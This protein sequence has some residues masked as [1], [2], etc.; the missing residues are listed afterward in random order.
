MRNACNTVAGSEVLITGGLGFIGSNLAQQLVKAEAKVTILDAMLESYGGN[1]TNVKGIEDKIKIVIGDIRD[2]ET[3][4]RLVDGKDYI[5]HLAAQ[6]AHV[7]SMQHPYLDVDINCN[8]TLNLLEACRKMG[9]RVKVVYSGTR[10]QVGEPVYLPVDENHPLNPTDIYGADKLAAEKYLFVY[11][12]AYDIRVT[13]L[14]LNNV[15][16]PRCQMKYGHYG[17]L[18]WFMGLAMQGKVIPVFGEGNQTRDFVYVDDVVNAM[19]AA[20]SEKADGEVFFIGSGKETRFL[21]M[22]KMVIT[23]VGSGSYEHVPFP[24]HVKRI[25][26]DRFIVNCDKAKSLLGWEP[27]V[28]LDEGIRKTTEFYRRQLGDYLR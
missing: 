14:R 8:G 19:L 24:S 20:L 10:A 27:N 18:N 16:G 26:I 11:Q 5:F 2:Q 7:E 17:I 22:V 4:A 3:V 13:S 21:D 15:Y 6:V 9:D 28:E 1:M 23:A 12:G 25:D